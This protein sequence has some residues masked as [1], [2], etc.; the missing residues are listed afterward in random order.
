[1]QINW[2]TFTAQTINFLV[3]VWLLKRFLY[4]PIV[5]AM[6]DREQQLAERRD[7]VTTAQQHAEQEAA[8]Y[9]RRN[10]EW[11]QTREE[12]LAEA[13]RDVESWKKQHLQ[14][15]RGEVD[16]AR[17]EWQQSIKRERNTFLRDLRQRAGRQ[18]YQLTRRVMGKLCSV[19]LE[20][21]AVDTFADQLQQLDANKRHEIAA[22]IRDL[23]HKLLVE[24][25]FI[26]SVE[27]RQQIETIIHEHLADAVALEFKVV[28]ELICGIELKAAGFKIAWSV[29]ETL[30]ELEDEFAAA[31]DAAVSE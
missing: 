26:L 14:Q 6:E 17:K 31:L 23:P 28:P 29:G 9:H 21:Q 10:E 20:Q 19:D 2:I 25:A 4:G 8:E 1:M 15:A 16:Q 13:G 5:R 27:H 22:T 24:T 30:E 12:L 18:V 11:E 7:E 3:L